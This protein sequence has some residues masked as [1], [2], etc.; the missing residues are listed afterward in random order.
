ME[1]TKIFYYLQA[2]SVRI[3][4]NGGHDDGAVVAVVSNGGKWV[5]FCCSNSERER[6]MEPSRDE[7]MK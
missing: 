4:S 2:R 3:Y 1:K 7:Y 6:E 5:V